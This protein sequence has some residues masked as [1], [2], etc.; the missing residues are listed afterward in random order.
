MN[1]RKSKQIRAIAFSIWNAEKFP[2]ERFNSINHLYRGMK[3][4][5]TRLNRADK[6]GVMQMSGM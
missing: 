4:K 5:Y 6:R 3:K 1:G 2:H